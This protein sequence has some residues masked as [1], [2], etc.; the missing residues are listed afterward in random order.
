MGYKKTMNKFSFGKLLGCEKVKG[1]SRTLD[2]EMKNPTV[3]GE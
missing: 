3:D 1:S 2:L